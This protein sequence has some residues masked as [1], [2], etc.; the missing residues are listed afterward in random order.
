MSHLLDEIVARKALKD[1]VK[2]NI[3][4]VNAILLCIF[5]IVHVALTG[6]LIPVLPHEYN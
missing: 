2:F 6:I 4:L 5:V 1:L 3:V